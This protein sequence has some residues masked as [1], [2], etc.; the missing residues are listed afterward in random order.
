MIVESLDAF[1][2]E[3][4][5][6]ATWKGSTSVTVLFDNAY[7][8]SGGFVESTNPVVTV[9]ASDVPSVAMDDALSVRSVSYTVQGIEPDSTG[10]I[11]VL[12]L[13]KV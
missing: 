7:Q 4:G 2:G 8:L 13:E 1:F 5:E 6:T 12:Q 9:K 11:L 10:S 3:F